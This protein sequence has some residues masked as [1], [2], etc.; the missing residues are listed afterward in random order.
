[1]VELSRFEKSLLLLSDTL[2]RIHDVAVQIS[3]D[4]NNP[5][6]AIRPEHKEDFIAFRRDLK[7][8]LQVS[9]S[10]EGA[11]TLVTGYILSQYLSMCRTFQLPEPDLNGYSRG[12]AGIAFDLHERDKEPGFVWDHWE[13]ISE[14]SREVISA[15]V[16]QTYLNKKNGE[17]KS[18]DTQNISTFLDATKK[19]PSKIKQ[20]FEK[21]FSDFSNKS[22]VLGDYQVLTYKK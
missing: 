19:F 2:D 3:G 13:K 10:K 22:D 5:V 6:G 1:M 11:E 7:T 21:D 16:Y 12:E 17:L 4:V 20:K 18:D 14:S 15:V 9:F 8:L